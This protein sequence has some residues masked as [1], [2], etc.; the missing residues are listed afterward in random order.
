MIVDFE[1]FNSL[2]FSHI[3]FLPLILI[4]SFSWKKIVTLSPFCQK[5]VF[6]FYHLLKNGAR[7]SIAATSFK[8]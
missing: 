8:V 4:Y 7:T 6:Y 5:K 2:L 3:K 1:F